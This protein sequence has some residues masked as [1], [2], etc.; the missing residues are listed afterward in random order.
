MATAPVNGRWF[1]VVLFLIGLIVGGGA[2][3]AVG[4]YQYAALEDKHDQDIEDL[5]DVRDTDYELIMEMSRT[6]VRIETKVDDLR[7]E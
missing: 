5:E 6:L 2:A 7:G 1:Q 3:A 4:H